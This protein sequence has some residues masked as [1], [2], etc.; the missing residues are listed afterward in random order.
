MS[1]K[2]LLDTDIGFDIDD[3]VCLAYLLAHPDC[4]LL[5]ITTVTGEPVKRAQMVSALCRAAGKDIPI[6]PGCP[7][8]FLVKQR[9]PLAPQAEALEGMN[10]Q[11]DFPQGQ[12][13]DFL[14]RTIRAHPGE[15]TLLTIGPLTNIG[16]LF[17]LDPEI[18]SLLKA[19]VGMI[20]L[21]SNRTAGVGPLEYNA[22]L[23]PHAAA[24]LY[25]A[26]T[27]V[28][29]S[30]GLEITVQVQMSQEEVR[31]RFTAPLLQPVLAFAEIWFQKFPYG[32]TFHDP[33]AAAAIFNPAICTFERGLVE[34][35]MESPR[36]AGLTHWKADP[37]DGPHEMAVSVDKDAFFEEYFSV[38]S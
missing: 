28:H 25:R 11:K 14:R 32:I 6:F 18:P 26:R 13:V 34:V 36:L 31:R 19:W 17:T 9:Q 20:G 15:I 29:R 23:D 22:I 1:E 16:L 30:I 10:Y 24:I 27:K 33:L 4:E 12:A 35:E 3:A 8:P 37:Q 2:I 38:F 7:L 21:F 5:G